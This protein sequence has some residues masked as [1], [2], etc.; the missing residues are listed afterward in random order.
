MLAFSLGLR[1]Y[2]ATL[3][4]CTTLGDNGRTVEG[5]VDTVAVAVNTRVEIQ[6]T[7][8]YCRGDG[9]RVA[10]DHGDIQPLREKHL[11]A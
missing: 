10:V 7:V 4:V 1:D 9:D 8:E 11:Q 6:R 5:R 3:Y 2:A